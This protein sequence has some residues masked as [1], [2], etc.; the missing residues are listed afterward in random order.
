MRPGSDSTLVSARVNLKAGTTSTAYVMG[1]SGQPTQALLAIDATRDHLG[2]DATESEVYREVQRL[3]RVN[4]AQIG[5]GDPDLILP[6]Q[7]IRLA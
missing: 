2:A 5:P 4:G 1:S 3:W 7:R 6:G